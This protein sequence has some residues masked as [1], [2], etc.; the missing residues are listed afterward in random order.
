MCKKDCTGKWGFSSVQ[1]CTV[2]LRCIAYG[3]PPDTQDDY[4]RMSETTATESVLRFCRAVVAVFGKFYLRK[5]TA[6]DTARIMAQNT[7]R[8]FPGMLVSIDYALGFEELPFCLAGI[9]QRSH[10]RVQ[11]DT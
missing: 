2:A 9:V 7:A 3:A 11:C 1:K 8:G 6:E 10:R 5:P 4:L